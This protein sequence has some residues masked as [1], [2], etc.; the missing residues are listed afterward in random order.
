MSCGTRAQ[1]FARAILM[2]LDSSV[3]PS[4]LI[5]YKR[6]M[7]TACTA[8]CWWPDT[9]PLP[10]TRVRS[11][12]P[13]PRAPLDTALLVLQP[14]QPRSCSAAPHHC[15]PP[16]AVVSSVAAVQQPG[17]ETPPPHR[18]AGTAARQFV[19]AGPCSISATRETVTMQSANVYS[20]ENR[21]SAPGDEVSRWAGLRTPGTGRSAG[22]PPG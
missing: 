9:A 8:N 20:S 19:S 5:T 6:G 1:S 14:R 22:P 10:G 18:H 17:F 11:P 16:S 21:F 4:Q 3:L 7:R 12:T 13:S 15:G 2:A